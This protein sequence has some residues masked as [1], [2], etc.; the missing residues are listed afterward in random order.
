[1]IWFHTIVGLAAL[2]S[3]LLVM[4]RTKGTR[5]HRTTGWI[6]VAS[7]YVL[8]VASFGIGAT[9]SA[10]F[11]RAFGIGWGMF[12]VMALVSLATLTGGLVPI[13]RRRGRHW[14]ESH[15]AFML[16]SYVG[17]V[18]AT[19]SHFMNAGYRALRPA[20]GSYALT[21]SVVI[22]CGWVLP[23]AAGMVLIPRATDRYART[24]AVPRAAAAT[25]AAGGANT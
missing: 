8:C 10:P 15:V 17:L 3:G 18:M 22:G 24:F 7:M 9:A 19:N 21:W 1:M 25:G 20:L 5:A 2:G 6:Y 11:V 4:L 23:F 13:L 16:W 14:F 12:H